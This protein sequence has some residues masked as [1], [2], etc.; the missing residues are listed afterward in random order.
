MG[1][2]GGEDGLLF[3]VTMFKTFILI[4]L[5]PMDFFFWNKYNICV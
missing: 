5:K 3:N 2:G 1:G 4:L